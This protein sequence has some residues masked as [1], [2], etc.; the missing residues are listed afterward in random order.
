MKMRQCA[1][2][3]QMRLR[4]NIEEQKGQAC[5]AIN[6]KISTKDLRDATMVSL[7]GKEELVSLVSLAT[8]FIC[9]SKKAGSTQIFGCV[10]NGNNAKTAN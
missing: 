4:L 9:T 10:V 5:L 1:Q 3:W 6:V 7:R 8:Q 2:P